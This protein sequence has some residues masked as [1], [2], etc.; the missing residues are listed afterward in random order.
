MSF[1]EVISLDN[2]LSTGRSLYLALLCHCSGPGSVGLIFVRRS[3]GSS[4]PETLPEDSNTP[5]QGDGRSKTVSYKKHKNA[6]Q[7]R[8]REE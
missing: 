7:Q 1:P 4:I 3:L 5:T 6:T 2:I 8:M